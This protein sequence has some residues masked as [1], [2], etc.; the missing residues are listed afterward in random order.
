M[1]QNCSRALR[2]YSNDMYSRKLLRV[3]IQVERFLAKAGRRNDPLEAYRKTDDYLAFQNKTEDIIR[4]Q[5][6]WAK[7]HLKD[8]GIN[9]TEL[10]STQLEAKIGKYLDEHMPTFAS[11]MDHETVYNNLLAAFEYSIKAAYKRI[12]VKMLKKSA[13]D[14]DYTVNFELT[15]QD[16]LDALNNDANY[17]LN[18]KSKGYDQTTKDRLVNI[19]R[20]GRL[21]LDT[22][23]EIASDLAD[24]VDGISSVRGF[25]IA[26]TETANAFGTA[27]NA[28][29]TE[30]NVP[31]KEWVIAGPH[32]LVDVCDDNEADGPIPAGDSFSSGDMHEPAH[33]NCECY[34]QGV[35]L[36]LTTM[37]NDELDNLI[38]WDGS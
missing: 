3:Q 7:T 6:I 13:D 38:L 4:D 11:K 31:Q 18:T 17:L 19:V 36:D 21:N 2:K 33:I 29:L 24:Q 35:G 23:D 28:F 22:Y 20:D 5:I 26:N 12:G 9:S 8:M 37:S 30:N 16:Y 10:T 1:L 15:N 34:T 27:N 32:N 25:M 14:F